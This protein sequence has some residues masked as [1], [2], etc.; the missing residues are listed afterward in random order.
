MGIFVNHVSDFVKDLFGAFAALIAPER[1]V[2]SASTT[3][4]MP[5][6]AGIQQA[7]DYALDSSLRGNDKTADRDFH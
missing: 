3:T 4:A 2:R 6:N 7:I 1:C 5:A